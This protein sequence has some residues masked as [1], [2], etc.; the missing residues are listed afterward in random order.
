MFKTTDFATILQ[1]AFLFIASVTRIKLELKLYLSA[2]Y[3]FSLSFIPTMSLPFS[4]ANFSQRVRGLCLGTQKEFVL[5]QKDG[6]E[7]EEGSGSFLAKSQ[8]KVGGAAAAAG[9]V[10]V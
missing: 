5:K 10:K 4:A 1:I 3:L 2:R 8:F 6:E 7:F 9:A